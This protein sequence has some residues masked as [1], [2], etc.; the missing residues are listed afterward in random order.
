DPRIRGWAVRCAPTAG[1]VHLLRARPARTTLRGNPRDR[2]ASHVHRGRDPVGSA[3]GRTALGAEPAAV[4]TVGA[5]RRGAR[6]GGAG[7]AV[8]RAGGGHGGG[9]GRA[10]DPPRRRRRPVPRHLRTRGRGAELA[11]RAGP[12]R[13]GGLGARVRAGEP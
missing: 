10:T 9:A 7:G 8:R 6:G 5:G 12:R 1:V 3:P 11:A 13:G 2:E 4:G